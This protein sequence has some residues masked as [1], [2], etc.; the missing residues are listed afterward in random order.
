MN[1]QPSVS[2]LAQAG[3]GDLIS[4]GLI[5][6]GSQWVAI[7]NQFSLFAVAEDKGD[8]MGKAAQ[9]SLEILL[10]DIQTNL[11]SSGYGQATDDEKHVLATRCVEESFENINDYLISQSSGGQ[12]ASSKGVALTVMQ[13]IQGQ[14]SVIQADEHCCLHFCEG[15]LNKL[16]HHNSS[17]NAHKTLLGLSESLPI[18]S[19]QLTLNTNDLLLTCKHD[20][21][22]HVDEEFLR[23]TLTRFQDNL[24][25]AMRQIT[26]KAQRSGMQGKPLLVIMKINQLAEKPKS[27][28]KR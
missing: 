27:W 5:G 26:S 1:L 22:K 28:F 19:N 14:C 21:L 10:D 2:I 24:Q 18:T 6:Y 7:D 9:L 12:S 11:S 3:E 23:V 17:D 25:M 16:G 4:D 20:L 13:V 15:K 8:E